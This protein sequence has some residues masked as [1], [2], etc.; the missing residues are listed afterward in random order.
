[1]AKTERTTGTK[2]SQSPVQAPVAATPDRASVAN[3]GGPLA[4]QA[5]VGSPGSAMPQ[6]LLSLQRS[7]G[8][9]AVGQAIQRATVGE[10]GGDVDAGTQSAIEGARGGGQTLDK[11]VSAQM[12]SAFGASFDHVKVHTDTHADSLNRSMSA[13]AFTL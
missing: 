5:A 13:K 2:K 10:R 12:S 3:S 11:A 8:N 9:R 7:Y 1:M 6:A 4:M